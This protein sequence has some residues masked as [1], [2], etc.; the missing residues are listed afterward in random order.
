MKRVVITGL[1]AFG[2]VAVLAFIFSF[3]PDFGPLGVIMPAVI[4]ILVAFMWLSLSGNKRV[5]K[6]GADERAQALSA[7][8]PDGKAAI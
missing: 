8:P 4:G 5:I 1:I 7:L 2:V 3:V 6:V